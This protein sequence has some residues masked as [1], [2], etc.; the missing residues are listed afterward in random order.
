MASRTPSSRS[1]WS[2]MTLSSVSRTI[3][4]SVISRV[5]VCGGMPDASSASRTCSTMRGCWSWRGDRLT[6]IVSGA[7]PG[8]ALFGQV[9]R[10]IGI[11]QQ[12]LGGGCA[13]APVMLNGDADAD[14]G[15]ELYLVALEGLGQARHQA[16]GDFRGLDLVAHLLEQDPEL[17]ASKA[18]GG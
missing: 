9:H 14:S 13:A 2:R 11:A 6:D 4:V 8:P 7:S 17:V 10:D 18:R 5:R 16:L 12:L 15:E 1:S 3:A